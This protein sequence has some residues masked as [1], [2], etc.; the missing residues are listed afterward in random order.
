MLSGHTGALFFAAALAV[1]AA[2]G[3]DNL[4]V[5]VQSALYGRCAGWFVVAGVISGLVVHTA[6]VAFG[7]AVLLRDSQFAFTLLQIAGAIYL[8]YL[9]WQ[10]LRAT[11]ATVAHTESHRPRRAVLYAR[12]M[13]MNITNPKVS[14]FF[15]AFLPQFVDP[16][17]GRV[18]AQLLLLG[19]IFSVAALLIFG[20]VVLAAGQLAEYLKSPRAQVRLN[21]VAATVLAILAGR[22]L[23]AVTQ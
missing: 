21:R 2:P 12:G 14:L 20:G 10:A 3:P 6:A 4:F 7:I 1:A 11:P 9:A 19:A 16:T 17:R 23:F 15:I 22:L 5:L 8:L 13:L 18:S